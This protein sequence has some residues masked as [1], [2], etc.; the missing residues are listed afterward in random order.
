MLEKPYPT[1]KR[2]RLGP[3]RGLMSK[4]T[5]GSWESGRFLMGEVTLHVG[6]VLPTV[7]P[8]DY[9]L[10]GYLRIPFEARCVQGYLAHKKTSSPRTL[11]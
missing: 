8:M 5:G 11:P 3:Y 7:G 10:K 4:N 9:P 6:M 2:T 1:R